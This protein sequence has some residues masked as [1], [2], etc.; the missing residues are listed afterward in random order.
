MGS[1]CLSTLTVEEQN[2]LN[3]RHW[4]AFLCS[5]LITFFAGL[6]LVLSWR[7]F[8][9]T[10]CQR[11]PTRP[12]TASGSNGQN[13]RGSGANGVGAAGLLSS[14]TRSRGKQHQSQHLQQEPPS[15]VSSTGTTT[16]INIQP[17]Q[18]SLQQS[19]NGPSGSDADAGDVAD[20]AQATPAQIGWVTSAQDWAGGMM[21]GQTTTGRIMVSVSR[22]NSRCSLI[23]VPVD[24]VLPAYMKSPL[25]HT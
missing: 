22:V 9:W 2:C 1:G 4:Y 8:T 24:D 14:S 21:S 5:S 10:M 15:V 7:I 18:P 13:N 17:D 19:T 23:L 25:T 11:R 6:L 20:D 16:S 3:D 12:T